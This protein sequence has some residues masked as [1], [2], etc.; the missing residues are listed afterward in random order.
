M[1]LAGLAP[2]A[3]PTA[4]S[5]QWTSSEEGKRARPR[6]GAP[7]GLT[8]TQLNTEKHCFE[9]NKVVSPFKLIWPINKRSSQVRRLVEGVPVPGTLENAGTG[10]AY[11]S[12]ADNGRPNIIGSWGLGKSNA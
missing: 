6:G 11:Y 10:A 4:V 5:T 2:L 7:A 1:W 12:D 8:Y 9:L 3:Q